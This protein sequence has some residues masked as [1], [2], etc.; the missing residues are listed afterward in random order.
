MRYRRANTC[1]IKD[2]SNSCNT[3]T[4][5]YSYMYIIFFRCGFFGSRPRPLFL[6]LD[7]SASFLRSSS[8]ASCVCFTSTC[9]LAFVVKNLQR[10]Y[11]G[12]RKPSRTIRHIYHQISVK[13]KPEDAKDKRSKMVFLLQTKKK[14]KNNWI[15]AI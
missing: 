12:L 1:F 10:K 5:Y 7:V 3:F 4:Y 11:R 15:W 6:E 8:G 14:Q 9:P 2:R 13:E